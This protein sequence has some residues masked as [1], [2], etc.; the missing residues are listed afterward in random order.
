MSQ[1][2][3]LR[4]LHPIACQVKETWSEDNAVLAIMVVEPGDENYDAQPGDRV[5]PTAIYD[6]YDNPAIYDGTIAIDVYAL[7][8]KQY[9]QV[10]EYVHLPGDRVLVITGHDILPLDITEYHSYGTALVR[11]AS[12]LDVINLPATQSTT[13]EA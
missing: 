2:I 12:V 8:D 7:A 6:E 4:Q 10:P 13:Q 3:S 5:S 11:E 1:Y 9:D